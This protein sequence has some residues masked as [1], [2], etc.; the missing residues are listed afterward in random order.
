MRK[1]LFSVLTDDLEHCYITGSTEVAIHHVFGGSNRN[2]SDKYGFI[3]ALRPDYHNMSNHG[4]HFDRELDLK[5]KRQ[6]Q[7]YYEENIGERKQ[8]ISEFGKSWL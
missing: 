5:F 3:I 7:T 2:R 4:V 6:A 8:F 1:K